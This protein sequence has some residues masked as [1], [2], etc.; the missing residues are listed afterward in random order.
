M[1]KEEVENLEINNLLHFCR[2]SL[3]ISD[4]IKIQISPFERRGSD[5]S[6][7]RIRWNKNSAILIH[8]N[9]NRIENTL[10]IDIAKFLMEINIPV[11]RL[12]A[13]NS[14]KC[15]ILMEDIGNKTLFS[16][17][18][19]PWQK[20][21]TLYQKTLLIIHQ[22]HSFKKQ[23]FPYHRLKLMEDFGPELYRWEQEYFK[24]HFVRGWCKINLKFSFEKELQKELLSLGEKLSHIPL[25]LIHRDLQS[26]NIMVRN[27]KIYL[28]DFQ[29][30][31]F[32]N[33]F[34]D[35]GSL[36]CDPYVD[37]SYDEKREL[38]SFYYNIS[39]KDM[40]WEEFEQCFWEASAQRL[41]Q[42]LGAY[43]FLGLKKGL[44]SY[45]VYIPYALKNLYISTSK[46]SSLRFLRR[47]CILCQR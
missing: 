17:R 26:Q 14:D 41:M 25:S 22:L 8:Y 32:G 45:L 39:E 24:E 6:F 19:E 23:C 7:F 40:D 2:K 15:F 47:L 33:L 28:I 29:G 46:V 4:S 43:G 36:I 3:G 44:K 37:L 34:Y 27:N 38:L 10:Y 35:L 21:R 9:P 12:I 1:T 13:S 5:R 11:P 16:L 31:R 30:M 20:R 42:A 18:K